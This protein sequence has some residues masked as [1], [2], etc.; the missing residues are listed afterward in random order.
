MWSAGEGSAVGHNHL[1]QHHSERVASIV[2]ELM[3]A[4]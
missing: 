3:S 2:V 4:G 1:R